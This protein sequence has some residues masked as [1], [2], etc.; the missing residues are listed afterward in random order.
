M[1]TRIAA[2]LI[3][4]FLLSGCG[5]ESL[6]DKGP[7]IIVVTID[8]LR[9]DRVAGYGYPEMLTPNADRLAESGVVFQHAIAPTGTTW[10]S[11][12]SMLTGLYPRYHGVRSNTHRLE[13]GV[14]SI[15]EL[16]QN[17]GYETGSFVSFKG[18]HFLCGLDRGFSTA[19]DRDRRKQ[20]EPAIR[21]GRE[22]TDMALEWL[23][24]SAAGERPMFMW[25]HLFEPHGPY[26]LTD[27]SRNWIEQSGYDG[28]LADHGATMDL[29]LKQTREITARAEDREALNQI[30][31]GEVVLAD[32]YF[33][34]IIDRLEQLGELENTVVIFTADHGQGLSEQ[35]RMG[36]GPVLWE[37]VLQV[38]LIIRDFRTGPSP[39][40]V[41]GTVGLVDIAP[42]VADLALGVPLPESQGRSLTPALSGEPMESVDY[43]AE[44]ALQEGDQVGDWYDPD[45][46][47]FYTQGLKFVFRKDT[48]RAFEVGRTAAVARPLNGDEASAAVVEFARSA[49]EEF[50]AGEMKTTNAELTESDIEALRSLGYLQ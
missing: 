17:G 29:L 44:V 27:Y 26:E 3:V 35:N 12:S 2:C 18:M 50:L 24:A 32:R 45:A 15:A 25:L 47:A 40:R 19:S 13:D 48:M 33:G 43:L 38:P 7:N 34:E 39:N 41:T 20:G 31:D 16:L 49:A 37:Q 28:V 8:T 14:R 4:A 5:P 21:D 30:Y 9:A 22:T 36:H 10:P 42:T 11:H 46:L 23:D 1:S 6:D